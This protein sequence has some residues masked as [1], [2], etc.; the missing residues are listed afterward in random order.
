M[1][2][3]QLLL[4]PNTAPKREKLI[5][6]L[7]PQDVEPID[8]QFRKDCASLVKFIESYLIQK[9]LMNKDFRLQ[10]LAKAYAELGL[11]HLSKA[12]IE[13]SIHK[14][15]GRSFKDAEDYQ[16][17][18]EL[19]SMMYYQLDA[20][21]FTEQN[22]YISMAHGYLQAAFALKNIKLELE[23]ASR[24]KVLG[25]ENGDKTIGSHLYQLYQL[26]HQFLIVQEKN[27][28][29]FQE[30]VQVYRSVAK[31]LNQEDNFIILLSMINISIHNSF[32]TNDKGFIEE[33]LNLY[34][35][36]LEQGILIKENRMS[37][38]TFLNCCMTAMHF[39]QGGICRAI[40]RSE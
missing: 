23:Q 26:L 15:E 29:Q 28:D 34:Q 20:P 35:L 5:R 36:G 32:E 6:K 7:Y 27:L 19:N 22:E 21:K 3:Q 40:F 9:Q 12:N 38:N 37:S 1:L 30:L 11:Y 18:S 25:E 2:F 4:S 8:S 17:L 10:L 16:K 13:Q 31:D 39:G 33:T 24:K 14:L